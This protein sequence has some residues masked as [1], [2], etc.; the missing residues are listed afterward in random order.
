MFRPQQRH[1]PALYPGILSWEFEPLLN[2]LVAESM[3]VSNYHNLFCV[4]S[5]ALLLMQLVL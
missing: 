3:M 2:S 5:C 1:M 4:C